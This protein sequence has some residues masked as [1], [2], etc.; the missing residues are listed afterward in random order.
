MWILVWSTIGKNWPKPFQFLATKVRDPFINEIMRVNT[1]VDTAPSLIEDI[2]WIGWYEL[3]LLEAVYGGRFCFVGFVFLPTWI[4]KWLSSRLHPTKVHSDKFVKIFL[5]CKWQMGTKMRKA[6]VERKRTLWLADDDRCRAGDNKKQNIQNILNVKSGYIRQDQRGNRIRQLDI[7]EL[8]LGAGVHLRLTWGRGKKQLTRSSW[9]PSQKFWIN[10]IPWNQD[11]RN[12]WTNLQ[13]YF[14]NCADFISQHFPIWQR[15]NIRCHAID[16]DDIHA[17]D[18]G[19]GLKHRLH[20]LEGNRIK[21]VGDWCWCENFFSGNSPK[22]KSFL[23]LLYWLLWYHTSSRQPS[24]WWWGWVHLN[25]VWKGEL[26]VKYFCK[27]NEINRMIYGEFFQAH[28]PIYLTMF[29]LFHP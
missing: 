3:D 1:T 20:D 17:D 25:G 19:G 13:I 16:D 18:I 9:K 10:C 22:V 15:K 8:Q 29:I 6:W 7:V 2:L 23:R 21:C 12:D 11:I 28:A 14:S 26:C 24:F 4:F 27:E 5:R